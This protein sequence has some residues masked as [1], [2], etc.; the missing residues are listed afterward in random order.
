MLIVLSCILVPLSVVAMWARN[1]ILNTD[2]YVQTVA[3]LARNE[4]IVN[5]VSVRVTNTLF[6]NIDVETIAKD[7]LP[8][9]AAFLAG[10][11]TSALRDFVQEITL[12]FFESEEFQRIWDEANRIA[13]EQVDK[14]LT[15]GGPT[16]ETENGHVVLD[17]SHLVERVRTELSSRGVS[18]FD[19]LPIGR[20]VAP[21][22]ALRC[23]GVEECA[24]RCPPAQEPRNRPADPLDRLRRGRDL[25]RG[26]SPQGVDAVG[27]R[28]RD[29]FARARVR[30]VARA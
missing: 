16:L 2:D 20:L 3:P 27:D 12:R 10:P 8:E 6:D 11:V 1:Q 7:A 14:A 22:R 13:H 5:A 18:V 21:L 24:G 28:C 23:R 4:E 15:G 30:I 17:L 25:A 29:R 9:Q 19:N 26:R